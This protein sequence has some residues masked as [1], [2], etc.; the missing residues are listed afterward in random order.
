MQKVNLDGDSGRPR[1]GASA[2]A[3][4][5]LSEWQDFLQNRFYWDIVRMIAILFGPMLAGIIVIPLLMIIFS[6][7]GYSY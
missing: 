1:P 7:L 2:P 4:T 6:L 3:W 5:P